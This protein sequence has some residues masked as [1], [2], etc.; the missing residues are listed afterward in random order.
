MSAQE[1]F[2]VAFSQIRAG[3]KIEDFWGE[4][5]HYSILRAASE[6]MATVSSISLQTRLANY[7]TCKLI[8]G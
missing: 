8:F 1:Q 7:K 4:D 3:R 5:I 6:S 2:K